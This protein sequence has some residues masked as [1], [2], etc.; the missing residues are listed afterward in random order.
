MTKKNTE[1]QVS[2]RQ[3]LQR[4]LVASAS[5]GTTLATGAAHAQQPKESEFLKIDPWT[6]TQRQNFPNPTYGV[7]SVFEKKVT[8]ETYNN[9]SKT[10]LQKLHG[11]ITPNGLHFERHH[12]G[13]PE[14]NP[15]LHRLVIHGLVDRP[16]IFKI[17]RAHV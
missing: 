6:K 2:R 11:I 14:I 13:I 10:P 8:R 17:G 1:Q 7:P 3:F 12:G 9:G 15:D 16:M 5:V 4:S